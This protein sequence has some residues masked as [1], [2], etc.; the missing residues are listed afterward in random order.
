[1]KR[2]RGFTL[3]EV[4]IALTILA[5]IA[6]IVYESFSA[7]ARGIEAART[8]SKELR[9]RK[10]LLQSLHDNF[11]CA[12]A[13]ADFTNALYAFRGVNGGSGDSAMDTV[14]FCSSAP[15]A[16]GQGL[17]GDYKRVTIEILDSSEESEDSTGIDAQVATPND[18]EYSILNFSETPLLA[19]GLQASASEG[20]VSATGGNEASLFGWHAKVRSFDITYF[21]GTQWVDDWDSQTQ[22]ALPW[23]VQISINFAKSDAELEKEKEDGID[24][25][26]D[27]DMVMVIA[28][29]AGEG[30]FSTG[31]PADTAGGNN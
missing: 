25:E 22:R 12:Y 28:I 8:S 24:P 29:P 3:I 7:A 20:T 13:G 18:A 14:E 10:F 17:P 21:D 4:V 19:G 16:G 26:K 1:M 31:T 6:T 9:L 2:A 11:T 23:C 30:R 15:L 27:P 5:V